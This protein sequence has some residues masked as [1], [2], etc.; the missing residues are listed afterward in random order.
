MAE[1]IE[2]TDANI[3]RA[4]D[5]LRAGGVVAFPTETVYGLG[6]LARNAGAVQRLYALKGR[7]ANNPLIAHVADAAGAL[8]VV[9]SWPR[10]A[11]RLARHFWPGPLTLVLPRGEDIPLEATGGLPTVAVRAPAHPVARALLRALGGEPLSAPSANPSGRTSATTANHVLADFVDVRSLLVLDGGPSPVGIESTVLDLSGGEPTILRP[12]SVAA[13]EI[14]AVLGRRVAVHDASEQ[15]ASPGTALRHYAPVT[16]ARRVAPGALGPELAR[17]T[18][19]V[20][21]LAATPESA[22]SVPA[23]VAA[24]HVVLTMPADR[25]AY[26]AT[27]YDALRRADQSACAQILI[28]EPGP[29]GAPEWAAV[30]DRIA[31]ATQP[32]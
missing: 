8:L 25:T 21:A 14:E 17:C 4:A 15:G 26:A 5:V 1:R 16:P 3:R 22:S 2:P 18:E 24:R 13:A 20:A 10:E 23:S 9:G 29:R 28:E 19:R 27:L 6:A 11:E 31:R 30:L 7:P 32:G 12:G